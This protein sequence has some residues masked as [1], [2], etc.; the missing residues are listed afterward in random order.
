MAALLVF[1]INDDAIPCSLLCNLLFHPGVYLECL[2]VSVLYCSCHLF[3]ACNSI[4]LHCMNVFIQFVIYYFILFSFL[5]LKMYDFFP[6]E[7][8]HP[9]VIGINRRI[10]LFFSNSDILYFYISLLNYF[11]L[12]RQSLKQ[13]RQLFRNARRKF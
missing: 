8:I 10:I 2:S 6:K 7:A 12:S 13:S 11:N 4:L 9:K 3:N 1:N 5:L